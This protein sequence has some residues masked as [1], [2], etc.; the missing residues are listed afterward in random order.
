MGRSLTGS[1]VVVQ[2]DSAMQGQA[3]AA[4]AQGM[5]L[6]YVGS[7]DLINR[8]CRV[9]LKVSLAHSACHGIMHCPVTVANWLLG[10]DAY[11]KLNVK[12]GPGASYSDMHMCMHRHRPQV[13]H[14]K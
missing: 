7:L 1:R 9:E 12:A 5:A 8:K 3:Q 13:W 6:R 10:A 4:A 11:T 14:T 2:Y